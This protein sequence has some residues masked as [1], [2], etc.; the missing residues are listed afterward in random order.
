MIFENIELQNFRQFS[1]KQELDFTTDDDKNVTVIH[2]YNGSGKTTLLNAFVWLFYGS[3]TPDFTDTGRL[4]N[5]GKWEKLDDGQ[6]VTVSVKGRFIHDD[7]RYVAKRKKVVEK[8]S[9]GARDVKIDG[10][11][12]LSFFTQGGELQSIGGPQDAME[13]IL[14]E[15]LY[16]FFLFNGERIER[17]ASP[18]AYEQVETGIKVLLDIELLDRAINHL[19]GKTARDLRDEV[20]SHSGNEGEQVKDERESLSEEL[21]ELKEEKKQIIKNRDALEDE[22]EQINAKLRAQPELASLQKERDEKEDHL[23]YTKDQLKEKRQELA[24]LVSN[25]G[26]VPVVSSTL[27]KTLEILDEAHEEGEIPPPMK[28][29]FV[30]ELLELGECI[31]GRSLEED[32]KERRKV[33]AWRDIASSE[34]VSR[35]AETTRAEIK[36]VLRKRGETFQSNLDKLQSQRDDLKKKKRKLEERLSEISSQIGEEAPEE[37]YKALESRRS[38]IE[39]KLQTKKFELKETEQEIDDVKETIEEKDEKIQSLKQESAK[40]KLAQRRLE[41]V[42]KISSAIEEIRDL[43]QQRVRK[44]LSA[45]LHEIWNDIAIKN[46]RASLD[47]EYRLQLTKKIGDTHEPVRGASTGEKQVLS[48]AFVSSL[49]RKAQDLRHERDRGSSELFSGGKYPLIMDSPF[50]SL[51]VEYRRQVAEWVPKL[52]PQIVIIVSETQ[53]RKEVQQEVTPK[54]GKEWILECHTPKHKSK[55]IELHGRNFPYVT[56]AHDGFERTKIVEVKP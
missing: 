5:E 40:G 27:S 8:L 9:G 37:D 10:E 24:E 11:L 42:K 13:Q 23:E 34:E 35:V 25:D 54:I 2:G 3:F 22:L 4:V 17:L 14:P 1:E 44:D 32:S 18:K 6:Q 51:E 48:L 31:C 28:Q 39:S 20:T 49:V 21:E 52:A 38:Q 43:Q 41:A 55:E 47:S 46:Y 15:S 26:Y 33:N 30:D 56:K 36:K 19:D 16:P 12:S 45:S 29:Q 53:W 50:G 7:C